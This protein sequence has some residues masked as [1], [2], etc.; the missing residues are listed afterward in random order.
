MLGN[1]QGDTAEFGSCPGR[2][3]SSLLRYPPLALYVVSI[4]LVAYLI[5]WGPGEGTVVNAVS[6]SAVACFVVARTLRGVLH[7]LWRERGRITFGRVTR[8]TRSR[9]PTGLKS[10]GAIHMSLADAAL[11]PLC[12]LVSTFHKN[13][14][15]SYLADVLYP[16]GIKYTLVYHFAWVFGMVLT[17]GCWNVLLPLE[18]GRLMPLEKIKSFLYHGAFTLSAWLLVPTLTFLSSALP[19]SGSKMT[20]LFNERCL[21]SRH[22]RYVAEGYLG[23]VL[24]AL[25][26][27]GIIGSLSTLGGWCVNLQLCDEYLLQLTM[28]HRLIYVYGAVFIGGPF[29]SG[30]CALF[31]AS[32]LFKMR[33]SFFSSC[34]LLQYV[35]EASLELCVLSSLCCMIEP[36]TPYAIFIWLGVFF[37][38]WTV[39]FASLLHRYGLTFCENE[40]EML[41]DL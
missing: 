2:N 4:G 33:G 9:A 27:D 21:S 20:L 28:A 19:C 26:V 10:T 31:S 11:L 13:S 23:L 24:H 36:L 40:E 30:F 16:S 14:V 22:R 12:T 17:A 35:A 37:G 8:C 38:G 25:V 32:L 15:V 18:E 5:G 41:F 7:F 3:F 29:W 34:R 39:I 1:S 6:G